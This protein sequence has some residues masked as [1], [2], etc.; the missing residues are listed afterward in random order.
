MLSELKY[1]VLNN[2]PLDDIKIPI[3]T[4]NKDDATEFMDDFKPQEQENSFEI[5]TSI[6]THLEKNKF[7]I[8]LDRKLEIFSFWM[9]YLAGSNY[10]I[11]IKNKQE[12]LKNKANS[13]LRPHVNSMD[14]ISRIA[15]SILYELDDFSQCFN[16]KAKIERRA[17]EANSIYD[18]MVHQ[19][20]ILT[21]SYLLSV[22]K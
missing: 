19:T 4:Y 11:W 8:S 10:F 14:K 12:I 21:Q 22:Y 9:F 1:L 16:Y 18:E 2:L 13:N 5:L 17:N 20:D 15:K 7:K 6:V 3:K